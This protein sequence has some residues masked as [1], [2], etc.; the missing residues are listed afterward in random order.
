MTSLNLDNI[1]EETPRGTVREAPI[2]R[3]RSSTID[4]LP[5]VNLKKVLAFDT[6]DDMRRYLELPEGTLGK[7]GMA[8]VFR[9]SMI[10][11]PPTGVCSFMILNVIRNDIQGCRTP[12]GDTLMHMAA[13]HNRRDVVEYLHLRRKCPVDSEDGKRATPL[14]RAAEFGA[15]ECVR[16]L[17][18]HGADKFHEDV[19][20]ARPQFLAETNGYM[21]IVDIIS[22]YRKEDDD[23]MF[24]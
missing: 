24:E 22:S 17:L 21:N 7:Y 2:M 5:G 23:G 18:A 16:F 8:D 6:V 19:N 11:S 15:L 4:A 10:W 14:C 3:R 20:G 1:A 12:D 13:E 9:L